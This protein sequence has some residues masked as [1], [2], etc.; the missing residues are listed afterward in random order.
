MYTRKRGS[1]TG[2]SGSSPTVETTGAH[3][4]RP[5]KNGK[6]EQMVFKTELEKLWVVLRSFGYHPTD[7][8]PRQAPGAR[9]GTR[10]AR[11]EKVRR[12]ERNTEG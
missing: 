4:V 1:S 12:A 11:S 10:A 2:R 8:T 7:M 6:R 9:P 3:D 5:S